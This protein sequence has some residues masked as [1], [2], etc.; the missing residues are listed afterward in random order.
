MHVGETIHPKGFFT[1]LKYLAGQS[2]SEIERRL[3]YRTG[4]LAQG[5]YVVQAC[6]LPGLNE[7]NLMGYSQVSGDRFKTN[8]QYDTGKLNA[9]SGNAHAAE[10]KAIAYSRWQISGPD[11]L[12]KVIPVISH[13]D[14]ETYPPGTGVPQWEVTAPLRCRVA[15]FVEPY[16]HFTL[17]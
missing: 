17:R 15:A 11:S 10:L 13:S 9:I 8:G 4:R 14:W 6:D 1:Q 5:A 7:F 2:L 16:Q 3:G 12:V